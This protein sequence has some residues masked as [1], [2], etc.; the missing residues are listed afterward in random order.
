[1]LKNLFTGFEAAYIARTIF[2][3]YSYLK[4][5]LSVTSSCNSSFELGIYR[6]LLSPGMIDCVI[7]SKFRNGP[8]RVGFLNP[9]QLLKDSTHTSCNLTEFCTDFLIQKQFFETFSALPQRSNTSIKNNWR[10]SQMIFISGEWFK[11]WN[12]FA[13][14]FVYG[15]RS[16]LYRSN[17]FFHL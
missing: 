10:D 2:F 9:I 5:C 11:T 17:N 12:N 16:C 6:A 1:L 14:K 4:S 7:Q 8:W 3:I 13:K 15:I